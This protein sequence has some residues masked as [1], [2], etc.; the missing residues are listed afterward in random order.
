[1]VILVDYALIVLFFSINRLGDTPTL[2][3]E[4]FGKNEGVEVSPSGKKYGLIIPIGRNDFISDRTFGIEF[5]P[6]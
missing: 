2:A 1:M 4:F 5:S 6:S 3:K